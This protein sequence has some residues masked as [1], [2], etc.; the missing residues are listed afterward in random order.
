[1]CELEVNE[2]SLEKEKVVQT[3]CIVLR[4]RSHADDEEEEEISRV[5]LVLLFNAH[6]DMT[7]KNQQRKIYYDEGDRIS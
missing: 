6:E 3:I 5:A 1:M 2:L 4:I 7:R